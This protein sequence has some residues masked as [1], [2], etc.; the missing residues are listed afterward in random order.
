M[1]TGHSRLA[2][3]E[4]TVPQAY[5]ITCTGAVLAAARDAGPDYLQDVICLHTGLG[6]Q[7]DDDSDAD[8][9]HRV[10]LI[11]RRQAGRHA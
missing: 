8:P 4:A 3:L 2:L 11:L 1:R 10:V 6:A 7:P 9:K 5:T